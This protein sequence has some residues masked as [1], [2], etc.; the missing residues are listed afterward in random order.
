MRRLLFVLWTALVTCGVLAQEA[1]HFTQA[2]RLILPPIET[3]V[4]SPPKTVDGLPDTA[5]LRVA[6]PDVALTRS[7]GEAHAQET[8]TVW[9]RLML[10]GA[11]QTHPGDLY[12]YLPRWQTVGQV[13]I[14]GDGRLLWQS[15]GDLVW[16]G[17]NQPVWV[18]LD[19]PGQPRPRVLLLRMDSVPGLGGGVS[20][21]WVGPEEEI[22][23]R[24]RAR[25]LMQSDLLRAASVAFG[26][27]GLF[28]F[29]VWW[30]RRQESLY[31][32]CFFAALCFIARYMHF[33]GPLNISWIAPAWFGWVTVNS[34]SWMIVVILLFNFRLCGKSYRWLERAMFGGVALHGLVTLP[35][36]ASSPSIA[37]LAIYAYLMLML[38]ALPAAFLALVISW[39]VRSAP[40]LVV[41]LIGMT[42]FPFA[43]HDMLLQGYQLDLE[44]IYLLPVSQIGFCIMFA[45]IIQQRYI[46]GIESLERSH[47]L[48]A[49]RLAEREAELEESHARLRA[50]EHRE[51][52]SKER[53]RLMRDMHDGVGG[54]LTGALR[55]MEHGT[56]EENTLRAALRECIDEL[57]L[58]IDSLEPV[59]ADIT[60]LLGSLRFRLQPRLEAAGIAL[61]WRIEALPPLPWLTPG[62]AMHVMRIVQEVVTNVI[63]HADAR[64]IV[65]STSVTK[66][67]AC[68]HIDDNG[69]GFDGPDAAAMTSGHG[70]GNIA[71]RA[72]ALGGCA[73]WQRK[74]N[75]SG[76]RFMLSLPLQ[77][78]ASAA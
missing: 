20:S 48:L 47:E 41:A 76:T 53:Q 14:Y 3:P 26:V 66:D 39:R 56:Y 31:L 54:A 50:I 16:N 22:A 10:N 18:S 59:E 69:R 78:Q 17:F 1:V 19:P 51:L 9:Y 34:V 49:Q 24:Y 36:L 70:L 55:M 32:L 62:H 12:F 58:T 63:K 21:M 71:Y 30:K 42:G 37:A 38:V 60:V 52:L 61:R 68:I 11:Q 46:S 65:F 73:S 25:K 6:L 43:V 29:S 33:I 72:G 7:A 67:S 35:W 23:W 40:A 2:E 74:T 27:L 64:E 4:S 77:D 75:E 8:Q 44:Q 45:F 13:S 57:R 15:E 28:S 5:W